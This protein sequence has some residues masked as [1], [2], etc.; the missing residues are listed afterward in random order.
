MQVVVISTSKQ[1]PF[2]SFL[3]FYL[4]KPQY[5]Q[6]D[7]TNHMIAW[8]NAVYIIVHIIMNFTKQRV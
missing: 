4:T 2:G 7:Y 6:R 1:Q 5:C 3:C 8:A